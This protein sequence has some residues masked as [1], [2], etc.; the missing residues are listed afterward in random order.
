MRRETTSSPHRGD[1]GAL[2]IDIQDGP[3]IGAAC[4]PRRGRSL[5][6]VRGSRRSPNRADE[7]NLGADSAWWSI[8]AILLISPE[9][10]VSRA[11]S[12][13]LLERRFR[14]TALVGVPVIDYIPYPEDRPSAPPSP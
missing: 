14:D 3:S 7:F 9:L 13:N 11:L 4:D 2:P 6:S 1:D 10:E 12:Q 5:G 8:C